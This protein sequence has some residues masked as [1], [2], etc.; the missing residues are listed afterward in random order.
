MRFLDATFRT[1]K[2]CSPCKTS[3]RQ[4]PMYD[5]TRSRVYWTFSLCSP[6]SRVT[7][8]RVT[9]N[10]KRSPR[11]LHVAYRWFHTHRFIYNQNSLKRKRFLITVDLLYVTPVHISSFSTTNLTKRCFALYSA[12]YVSS[13]YN[14]NYWCMQI[15]YF[16]S[17]SFHCTSTVA[18]EEIERELERDGCRASGNSAYFH[19]RTKPRRNGRKSGHDRTVGRWRN[20]ESSDTD[21]ASKKT[22]NVVIPS[23]ALNAGKF[24]GKNACCF[25]KT[26]LI[27]RYGK[28]TKEN[29]KKG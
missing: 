11:T 25:T 13:V 10:Q 1:S 19:S 21:K 4:C 29:T 23:T 5:R 24:L 6:R 2:L 7:D 28:S 17:T 15:G 16:Q 26:I 3:A 9:P 22:D 14:D 8:R 27:S 20:T 12:T 18:E